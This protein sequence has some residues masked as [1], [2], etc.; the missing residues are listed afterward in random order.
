MP[1]I[2]T[3]RLKHRWWEEI[4]SGRKTVELRLRTEYWQKRLVGQQYDEIHIWCGYPAKTATHLLLRRK[5][6]G[7]VEKT[8]THEEFGPSPVD[9]FEIDVSGELHAAE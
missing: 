6:T 8:I 1:R 7:V 9:V 2:L 3:L 5:W 4:Q